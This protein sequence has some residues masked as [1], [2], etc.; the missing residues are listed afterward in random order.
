MAQSSANKKTPLIIFTDLDGTLLD[1]YNYSFDPAQEALKKINDAKIPLIFCTSKTR[2]EIEVW[3]EKLG[4]SYP[5]ISENGGAIFYPQKENYSDSLQT[6]TRNQYRVI[7]LGTYHPDLLKQF[8]KLKKVFGEKIRGFSEMDVS[9]VADFT[10]LPENQVA[11]AQKREYS[12][13]FLFTGDKGEMKKLQILVKKC[14]LHITRGGRFFHLLGDNDKGKAVSIVI[15]GYENVYPKL[16]SIAIGDSFNDLPM[17]QKVD[18]PVLVQKPKGIF[19]E[20]ISTLANIIR[21]PG[22]GPEG[23]NKALIAILTQYL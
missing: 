15:K 12:E 10:G 22:V 21:A 20:K 9:E 1:H 11:L 6:C 2:S 5:F 23:W 13:P 7:E 16:K 4:N 8:K 14:K 17:L 19:D 18:I 3:R